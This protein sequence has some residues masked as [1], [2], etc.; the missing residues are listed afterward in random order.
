VKG[1]SIAGPGNRLIPVRIAR[2]NREDEAKK[3]KEFQAVKVED[4]SDDV[5]IV[6][7]SQ[8]VRIKT[9]PDV[10]EAAD[11][12]AQPPSSP[13][14][15][16]SELDAPLKKTDDSPKKA[17]L[18]KPVKKDKKPVIQTIEDQEEYERHLADVKILA[19]ELGGLQ[20]V[21]SK[22]KGK[23][24]EGDV[25]MDDLPKFAEGNK[26]N[27]DREG[28]LY[29]FQFPPVLPRLYNP[30]TES[31]HHD[32]DVVMTSE[33]IDLTGEKTDDGTKPIKSE[34]IIIKTEDGVEAA[35]PKPKKDPLVKEEGFIGKLVVRES[36][37]VELSWGGTSM[38]LGRGVS[39]N[40]LST[41]VVTE[42]KAED[43]EGVAIG[44]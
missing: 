5:Q 43:P 14:R 25:D 18:A 16:A 4:G 15:R 37:K 17:R 10:D 7:S 12:I 30:E 23:D 34:E 11:G 6:S 1:K 3:K 38:V 41:V 20:T 44:M 9:E 33:K 31:K 42:N 39:A 2:E 19:Q 8:S 28:R 32:D 27:A 40:F 24:V 35:A 26:N 13:K 22:G 29:L 36:G 21:S